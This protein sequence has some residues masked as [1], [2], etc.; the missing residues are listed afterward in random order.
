MIKMLATKTDCVL[1]NYFKDLQCDAEV[2]YPEE[3][4][5]MHQSGINFEISRLYEFIRKNTKCT[6]PFIMDIPEVEILALF[7]NPDDDIRVSAILSIMSARLPQL[8]LGSRV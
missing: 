4:G 2:P 3:L 1:V 8:Q 7:S 6:R 5:V